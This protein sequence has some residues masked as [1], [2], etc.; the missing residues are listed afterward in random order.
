[1]LYAGWKFGLLWAIASSVAIYLGGLVGVYAGFAV[2]SG[3]SSVI[4]SA[5]DT[6]RLGYIVFW[7]VTI[8]LLG[9]IPGIAQGWLLK[10]RVPGLR[11][12]SLL[13]TIG[14]V[15][16]AIVLVVISR[17][18]MVVFQANILI[19]LVLAG[20]SFAQWVVLRPVSNRAIGWIGANLAVA[21]MSPW[22]VVPLVPL[23]SGVIT[24][25]A[26]T[27]ILRNRNKGVVGE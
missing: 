16:T 19:G 22:L 25:A 12:W 24:G 9:S 8:L 7:F 15:L 4:P 21:V 3:L 27:W 5:T 17:S 6:S 10:R 18:T 1:M 26:I 14:T 23:A 11:Q 2:A 20:A 13:S